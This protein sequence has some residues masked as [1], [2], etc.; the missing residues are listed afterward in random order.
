MTAKPLQLLVLL[1]GCVGT[2]AVL[3]WENPF[4]NYEPQVVV[5]DPFI[6]LHTGPGRGYPGVLCGGPG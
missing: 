3:A 6:E 2:P 1:L 5:S 4:A